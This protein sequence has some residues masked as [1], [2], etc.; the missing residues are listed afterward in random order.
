M[1]KIRTTLYILI[2]LFCT[3]FLQ[4]Q[5]LVV[6]YVFN[7]GATPE[8]ATKDGYRMYITNSFSLSSS[9][10]SEFLQDYEHVE[11]TKGNGKVIQKVSDSHVRMTPEE[12][13]H[14]F[15]NKEK[16]T[17]TSNTFIFNKKVYIEEAL[18][19]ME[20]KLTEKDTTFLEMN[21]KVATTTYKGREWTVFFTTELPFTGGVWKFEG[22]PGVILYAQ[23]EDKVYSFE[24]T[25]IE[26]QQETTELVNPFEEKETM[27]WEQYTKD[28]KKTMTKVVKS[29]NSD[30]EDGDEANAR[31]T[32]DNPMED[33]GFTEIK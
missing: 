32:F 16:N 12:G 24:A 27:S 29:M 8:L 17:V 13:K 20:W 3:S 31:I 15:K 23:S 4:A 26:T 14:Y 28:L 18:D 9:A 11:T 6:D 30:T 10:E 7:N 1:K 2:F 19:E 33:L 25:A 21:C 5:T 22:L